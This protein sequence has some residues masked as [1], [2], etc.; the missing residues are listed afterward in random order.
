MLESYTCKETL[1][2]PP[3]GAERVRKGNPRIQCGAAEAE[4][5]VARQCIAV[6][7]QSATA[8]LGKSQIERALHVE[9]SLCP[10]QPPSASLVH[11]EPAHP[12]ALGVPSQVSPPSGSS[13]L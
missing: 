13:A 6:I 9:L 1:R 11:L 8:R 7:S 4:A 2:T 5:P 3:R 12:G 10:P